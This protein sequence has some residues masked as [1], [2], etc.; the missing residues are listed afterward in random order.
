MCDIYSNAHL[1]VA[2]TRAEKPGDGCF[3]DRSLTPPGWIHDFTNADGEPYQVYACAPERRISH[4]NDFELS[5]QK[6]RIFPLLQRAWAFQERML[7]R[8]VV[9]FG[10]QEL[11]WECAQLKTCECCD[12]PGYTQSAKRGTFE[13]PYM[14]TQS[15]PT[16]FGG[17]DIVEPMGWKWRRIV[18]QYTSK[19]LTYPSDIFP[20]LQGIAKSLMEDHEYHAGL[21]KDAWLMANL[22]WR[23]RQK[24]RRSGPSR[25]EE[26][27]VVLI[28]QSAPRDPNEAYTRPSTPPW[29]GSGPRSANAWPRPSEW[30]AP[31]W[32][33]ASISEPIIYDIQLDDT[34]KDLASIVSIDTVPIGRDALGPLKSGSLRI[35]GRC[36]DAKIYPYSYAYLLSLNRLHFSQCQL[37]IRQR[38]K[39]SFVWRR[40]QAPE[41]CARSRLRSGPTIAHCPDSDFYRQEFNIDLQDPEDHD[42]SYNSYIK[43][44]SPSHEPT[45]DTFYFDYGIHFAGQTVRLME[46]LQWQKRAKPSKHGT[47][48]FSYIGF[49]CSNAAKDTFERVGC[50][51]TNQRIDA[52]LFV[53]GGEELVL[54]VV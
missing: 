1:T 14:T 31:S 16:Q 46:V 52:K 18:E 48:T 21:W 53:N 3:V 35:R 2:A 29:Q 6:K 39:E 28:A 12:W 4:I 25:Y 45:G 10:P 49:I 24:D 20:A 51:H 36:V 26:H 7:S 19:S 37:L 40:P 47:R 38:W 41:V 43:T 23:V 22:L 13:K 11:F 54:H 30:R 8:R 42:K 17:Q 50:F 5:D 9:H 44:S 27:D 32:S 33:W 15:T 34:T